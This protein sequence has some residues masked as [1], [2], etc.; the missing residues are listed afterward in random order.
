MK[1]ITCIM[2]SAFICTAFMLTQ[3]AW[4]SNI[5]ESSRSENEE[6][7]SGGSSG[8]KRAEVPAAK[9]WPG[10]SDVTVIDEIA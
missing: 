4:A 9:E 3:I 7:M 6:G 10:D 5:Q 8:D 1:K 2:L